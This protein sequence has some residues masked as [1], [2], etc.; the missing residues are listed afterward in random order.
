MLETIAIQICMAKRSGSRRWLTRLWQVGGTIGEVIEHSP[1]RQHLPAENHPGEQ[2]VIRPATRLGSGPS[3]W[4]TPAFPDIPQRRR[5]CRESG[6]CD[7]GP[8]TWTGG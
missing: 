2:A 3:L 1:R 7:S 6:E 4:T 5:E 8:A